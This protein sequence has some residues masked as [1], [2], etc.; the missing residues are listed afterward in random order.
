MKVIYSGGDDVLAIGSIL[1]VMRFV[2]EVREMFSD[3][4]N[5]LDKD[6]AGSCGIIIAPRMA[7]PQQVISYGR[8]A[9]AG[10][11]L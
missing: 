7:P 8:K 5:G 1:D 6:A 9:E 11:R 2:E 3:P 10:K 4:E